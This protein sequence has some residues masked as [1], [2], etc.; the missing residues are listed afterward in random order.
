MKQKR[1]AH[2]VVRINEKEKA[3]LNNNA[4]QL[5]FDENSKYIR[6]IVKNFNSIREGYITLDNFFKQLINLS[7][8]IIKDKNG[9]AD[10]IKN[11]L[12]G[13]KIEKLKKINEELNLD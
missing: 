2:L 11:H 5:N 6:Y 7:D 3:M 8:N 1:E 13:D 4:K 10:L 9:F 12:N